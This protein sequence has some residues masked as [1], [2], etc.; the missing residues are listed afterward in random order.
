M[1]CNLQ[2]TFRRERAG[3]GTFDQAPQIGQ[4]C[5]LNN[6]G[7]D[8][9]CQFIEKLLRQARSNACEFFPGLFLLSR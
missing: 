7:T 8:T 2:G 5:C 1:I 9:G 4:W 6:V 3:T